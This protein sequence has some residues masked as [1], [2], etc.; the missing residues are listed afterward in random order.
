MIGLILKDLLS[1]KK[2]GGKLLIMMA[3]YFVIFASS[4]NIAFLSAMVT[5]VLTMLVINTFAYDEMSKWN[6]YALSL[7]VK[8]HQIVL[9]KYL[10]T[11]AFTIV[12]I[13]IA[14][15]L[16]LAEHK[17]NPETVLVLCALSSLALLM[18]S[19]MLPLLFKLGT[20]KARIWTVIILLLP[21][22]AIVLL[23]EFGVKMSNSNLPF[24]SDS[25]VELFVSLT[26]PIAL[27][28]FI[29][30]YLLSCKIFERKE[31]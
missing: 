10:L 7:P 18:A 6:Y 3:L 22:A 28:L 27:L 25:T 2:S 24:F 1:L 15:V 5:I 31:I 12:G 13:L 29:G 26:V 17:M 14:V 30:S 8:K 16:Y 19:V 11:L 9:S 23:S 4:G 20:Q 21:T